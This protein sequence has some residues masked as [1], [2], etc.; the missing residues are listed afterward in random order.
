ML[1]TL[2]R[3]Q[4]NAFVSTLLLVAL[5][6]GLAV[7]VQALAVKPYK[8]PSESMLPTLKVGQRVIVERVGHHLGAT[9]SVGQ[10]IVF[11]PGIGADDSGTVDQC[12]DPHQGGDTDTP[13]ITPADEH[14]DATYIK[15]VVGVPGDRIRLRRGRVI[16]NGRKTD[17]PF[18]ARCGDGGGCSFRNTV[19]VPPDTVYV[20]G[21]NRGGSDDS[22]YW[23]P[24]RVSWVIGH[25]I[26]SYWPPR[27]IGGL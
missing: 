24:V 12:P 13:C 6:V 2:A 15:R 8:I 1:A 17:E 21:D 3:W 9:P 20:L 22:R 25:A 5:V 14:S 18:I 19:T 4:R 27:E 10:V 7:A 23:G 26:A 11:H 16:R